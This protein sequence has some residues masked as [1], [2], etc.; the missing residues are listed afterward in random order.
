MRGNQSKTPSA[1]ARNL[2]SGAVYG[3][4]KVKKFIFINSMLLVL[5]GLLHY[6][7]TF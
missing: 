6:C 7:L 5:G 1:T 4:D 3:Y 2:I